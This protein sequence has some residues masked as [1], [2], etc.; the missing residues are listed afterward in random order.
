LPV[1]EIDNAKESMPIYTI[2]YG[3]R[4]IEQLLAVLQAYGIA[5]LIDVRSAP[6]SRYK[7]EFSKDALETAVRRAGMRYVYMGDTLGGRPSDPGCYTP[8]GK[9]D[10]A[11][12]RE[13]DFYRQGISRLQDAFRQGHPIV[14][15][16]SEGK[17][18][19]CHR[20][21][22]IGRTLTELEIPVIHIDEA[23]QLQDHETIKIRRTGGQMSLFGEQDFIS[24]KRYLGADHEQESDAA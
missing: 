3:S 17:P 2:G 22:L 8:D 7:P 18:E 23:D 20:S 24:R 13:A 12:V 16:C 9:V 11:K 15:M 19:Q 21:L 1:P 6:Y 10:Y 4:S 14:L 5:Y